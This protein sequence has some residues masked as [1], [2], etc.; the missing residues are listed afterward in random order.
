MNTTNAIPGMPE[1]PFRLEELSEVLMR[2]EKVAYGF[3]LSQA[4]WDAMSTRF[5]EEGR[6]PLAPIPHT[7]HGVRT[8]VDP[9][10][11]ATEFSVAFTADAWHK[12]LRELSLPL[13]EQAP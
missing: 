6:D 1:R 7:F 5:V 9:S 3:F 12:R 8:A 4:L 10:L 13:Q 2:K 11:L